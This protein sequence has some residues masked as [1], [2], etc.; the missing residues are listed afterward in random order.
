MYQDWMEKIPVIDDMDFINDN[1]KE[2]LKW[3]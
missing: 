3:D 1:D 2:N